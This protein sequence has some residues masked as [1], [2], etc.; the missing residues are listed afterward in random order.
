MKMSNSSKLVSLI[1]ERHGLVKAVAKGARRPTSRFGAALEPITY[2]QCMY[3]YRDNREL[4][5]L[6]STDII[7][8]FMR[9]KADLTMLSVASAIVEIAQ[10]HTAAE[11]PGAGTFALVV[12]SLNDLDTAHPEDAEKHLWRFVLRLL[13]AAGYRPSLDRCLCCGKQPRETSVFFSFADGGFICSCS[14]TADKFGF[15]VSPGSLMVMKNLVEENVADMPKLK[16]GAAQKAIFE[17][18][19][20]EN[21]KRLE[22]LFEGK[23]AASETGGIK[24]FNKDGFKLS[25]ELEN[26]VESYVLAGD[27]SSE[28]IRSEMRSTGSEPWVIA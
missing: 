11:D 28:H 19:A 2:I 15:R 14:E 24:V 18:Y 21:A 22:V 5:T 8:P 1:T 25:D 4:Q 7:E 23:V 16:I 3:Y 9:L 20:V 13:G 17:K 27:L 26:Q 12:E 6:T 10:A